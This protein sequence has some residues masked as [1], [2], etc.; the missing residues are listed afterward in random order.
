MHSSTDKD[1]IMHIHFCLGR[2]SGRERVQAKF[3]PPF[4][5]IRKC[6]MTHEM[7]TAGESSSLTNCIDS[8]LVTNDLNIASHFGLFLTYLIPCLSYINTYM[9]TGPSLFVIIERV[10]LPGKLKMSQHLP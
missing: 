3:V 9:S 10:L 1:F 5:V 4:V 7:D 8:H 2:G 6:D